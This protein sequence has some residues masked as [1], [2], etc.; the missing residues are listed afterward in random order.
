MVL[1]ICT[2]NLIFIFTNIRFIGE[3]TFYKADSIDKTSLYM[4][5]RWGLQFP[6]SFILQTQRS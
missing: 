2:D 5:P 1:T 4:S 6:R 3:I